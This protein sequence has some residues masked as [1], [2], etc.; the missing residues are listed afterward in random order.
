MKRTEN[1]HAILDT[2]AIYVQ[3]SNASKQV[4]FSQNRDFYFQFLIRLSGVLKMKNCKM[5]YFFST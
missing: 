5:K 3:K 1:T 2:D 4:N